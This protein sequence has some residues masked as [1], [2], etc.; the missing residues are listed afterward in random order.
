MDWS[1]TR[2]APPTVAVPRERPPSASPSRS[3]DIA[4]PSWSTNAHGVALSAIK[5]PHAQPGAAG[6]FAGGDGRAS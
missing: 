6:A 3:Y 1:A 5:P 4:S 2:A